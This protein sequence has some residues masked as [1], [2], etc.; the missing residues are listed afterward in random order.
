LKKK[1][2]EVSDILV[3]DHFGK[4]IFERK[5]CPEIASFNEEIKNSETIFNMSKYFPSGEK[6]ICEQKPNEIDL[7]FKDMNL[8][9]ESFAISDDNYLN[10]IDFPDIYQDNHVILEENYDNDMAAREYN[11]EM[12]EES[13]TN[14]NGQNVFLNLIVINF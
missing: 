9:T 2:A 6:T 8:F 1:Y 14:M 7:A 12:Y 13:N 10:D 5:L 11:N 4:Q 3:E